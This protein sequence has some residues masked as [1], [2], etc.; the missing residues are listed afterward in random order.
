VVRNTLNSYRYHFVK[1]GFEIEEEIDQNIPKVKFDKDAVEGILINLFS[2]VIKFS[3]NT[4]KMAIKLSRTTKGICLIVADKG[5][6]IPS[7]EMSNIFTRFY[8]V[9]DNAEYDSSGSGLGLTLVKHVVDAH[10][11]QIEVDS[12][13]GQGSI[14]TISIPLNTNEEK[15]S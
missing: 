12:T 9:K 1:K 14:F 10:G 13:P 5:V 11:W 2:N 8:R 3:T 15:L 4:K 7:D 6:G